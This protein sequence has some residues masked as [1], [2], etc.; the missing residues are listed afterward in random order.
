MRKIL[1]KPRGTISQAVGCQTI[2]HTFWIE[3]EKTMNKLLLTAASLALLAS[4][5]LAQ[6]ATTTPAAPAATA[7][8]FATVTKDE[9]FTSKLKGLNVMNNQKETIGEISDIAFKGKEISALILSVGG[10]L[11]V[12]ER[13]VAV[14][15]DAVKMMY[16]AKAEKW[17]ATMDTNKDTLKNAP[18]FKYPK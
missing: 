10:F 15:P 17:T 12:G 16:D 18:E 4:P 1:T 8:K 14:A 2:D 7:A 6:T 11:G 13:Y 5:A 9:M 3:M